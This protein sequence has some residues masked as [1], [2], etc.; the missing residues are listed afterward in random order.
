[1]IQYKNNLIGKHFKSLMQ[2]L[3]LHVHDIT[4]PEQF[5]LIKAAGDLGARLWV[6]EI[7]DMENYLAELKTAIANVLDAFDQVDPL[8]ILVK[9]KL[10]LLAHIPD[11]VRRFGPLIRYATEIY[12]AFNGVFRLCSIFSNRQAPSRDISLKFASMGRVKHFLSGGF[13]WEPA[14]KRWIQAGAGVQQILMNDP[15]F[16]RHLGWVSPTKTNPGFIKAMPIH[17]APPLEWHQTKASAH[18]T[19]NHPPS[20]ETRWRRGQM[21]TA[22]SGDKIVLG[23]WVFA[24]DPKGETVIGRVSELLVGEKS[25]V[26]LEQFICSKN[27]HPEFGWPIL[28]RPNGAEITG[29]RGQSFV[30]LDAKSIQFVCSV[31][32]DCRKGS[33]KPSIIRKEVQ[34]REETHRTTMLI[35]HSDD[36]HFIILM[37]GLHNF[38]H[39]CRVLP[40]SLTELKPLHK[41]RVAFHKEMALQA[42]GLGTQ[43]RTKTAEKRRATAAAKKRAAE[44]A[45]AAAAEAAAAAA[46]AEEAVR[47]AERGEELPDDDDDDKE[48]QDGHNSDGDGGDQEEEEGEEDVGE[49]NNEYRSRLRKR[50]RR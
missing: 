13:W 45:A 48:I 23:S 7:D 18:Y 22:N 14:S 6:P 47:R 24:L 10:H 1:M 21:L 12:E 8:R 19:L 5:T 40:R 38:V 29:G 36:D 3:T 33:C 34:E 49:D 30:V 11:D 20:P 42:Q 4:T 44:E 9:I 27:L 37:A 50:K 41:D 17:R 32:H 16:Q 28:R 15:I 25:L 2:I 26:T 43:K 35:K 39:V 46:E 31:Q